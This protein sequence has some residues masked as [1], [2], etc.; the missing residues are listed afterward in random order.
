M[1]KSITTPRKLPRDPG[2]PCSLSGLTST[3]RHKCRR[4]QRHDS[5]GAAPRT[6]ET[7]VII[8]LSMIPHIDLLWHM[9]CSGSLCKFWK[10]SSSC[11]KEN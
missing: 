11:Q 2:A 8:T 1:V 9:R 3:F 7:I 10:G 4:A 5:S 6:S